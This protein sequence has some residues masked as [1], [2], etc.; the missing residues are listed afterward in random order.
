M[1]G[2]TPTLRLPL[3]EL[4]VLEGEGKTVRVI[5]GSFLGETAPVQT[6]SELF[7]ADAEL[8]ADFVETQRRSK[9][10]VALSAARRNFERGYGAS[11][12]RFVRMAFGGDVSAA[13]EFD[14]LLVDRIGDIGEI[15]WTA[16]GLEP[17][18]DLDED[19]D[20]VFCALAHMLWMPLLTH[21][22]NA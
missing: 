18:P 13:V 15:D 14:D 1:S 19:A 22:V 17:D 7:Y 6:C 8:A 2:S 10:K 20:A 9:S 4:P 5:A 16:L 3:A 21:E 11:A 12:D